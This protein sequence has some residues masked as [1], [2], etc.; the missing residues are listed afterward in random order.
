MQNSFA[1]SS[2]NICDSETA[3]KTLLR[4]LTIKNIAVIDSADIEFG[5]G[6]NVLTGETGAGKSIIIDSLNMLKG[7]RA[8]KSVIRSGETKAQVSALV[9]V[10][11]ETAA[12]IN[13]ETGIE[14]EDG[15]LMISRSLTADG[16]NA[17]RVNGTPVT[18]AVL[19][20]IGDLIINIHGQ[21]DN[22]SL[23]SK[24]VHINYLDRFGGKELSAKKE[25][26]RLLH[27]ECKEI[28]R[29]LNEIRTD[30]QDK[31]R[32]ADMLRFQIDE[33]NSADLTPGEE[34]QLE[35]R[36]NVLENAQ[37]IADSAN[38][39]YAIIN[40]GGEFG[41]SAYDALWNGIN[42]LENAADIDSSLAG[43]HSALTDAGYAI[44]EA[45][46]ELKRYIDN[47]SFDRGEL[48]EIEER[49]DTIYNLKRK[50][51]S[52]IEEILD[53]L[54]K[55]SEELDAI[56]NSDEM[57][58]KLAA[59]LEKLDAAREKA[60]AELTALRREDGEKL[61]ALI[62]HELGDLDMAKVKFSVKIEP[63]AY[64]DDGADDVEFLICTNVGEDFKP[65]AKIASG[66]ELS[67]VMLAIKSVLSD[68]ESADTL[69][70]DEV[71]TGVSGHAAHKLGVKLCDMSRKAQVLC[72]THLPQIAAM[73]DNH[74]LIKKGEADG[75]VRTTVTL[76]DRNM[77]IDEL[78]RTLGGDTITDITR[79]NADELLRRAEEYKRGSA[80]K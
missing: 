25:A 53:Y 47:I 72:I 57:E 33:I 62:M 13:D 35:E 77:R 51:G 76:L 27:T 7:E 52:G 50:Y 37:D 9:G 39:A 48:E 18:L 74:Y 73:A 19:K 79:K 69:I 23:L 8:S 36:R 45:L 64:R 2:Q 56:D 71:D 75:R 41:Q 16:K 14:I 6:F 26:Y 11:D 65:L 66:G 44:E 67:R 42:E 59:K 60:A 43:I 17:I 34:E 1:Q 20:K 4:Q 28:E 12:L 3:V 30:G 10:S 15:E 29:A 22:T 68:C 5:G 61:S 54:D 58:K 78:S 40:D 55:I 24:K 70:F 46:T 31:L 32:R 49:L 80:D 63:C 21:H 38:G